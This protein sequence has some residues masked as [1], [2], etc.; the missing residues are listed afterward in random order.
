MITPL[1]FQRSHRNSGVVG[2]S[3]RLVGLFLGR[4]EEE[5]REMPR[6]WDLGAG[7]QT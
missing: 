2:T 1:S 5:S 4:V 7:P 6:G 3:T